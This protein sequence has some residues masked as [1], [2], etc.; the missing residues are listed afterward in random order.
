MAK[1]LTT[2]HLRSTKKPVIRVVRIAGDTELLDRVEE[3]RQKVSLAK[4]QVIPPD[5]LDDMIAELEQLEGEL[6]ES[7]LV[8]RLRSIG[9][10][11]Y[12]KMV[13]AHPPTEK[14]IA[15]AKE[16]GDTANF[17]AET[18]A[19]ALL[20]ACLIEPEL[21]PE[22]ADELIINSEKFSA[23]EVEYLVGAAVGVNLQR[24][25]AELGNGSRGT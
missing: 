22:E 8:F 19:P 15:E 24:R 16:K 21:T 1:P 4:R 14:Q 3:M 9:A 20:A 7:M 2:D 13:L 6:D 11:R 25:I 23:A 5:G 10:K 12:E 18:L 17:N